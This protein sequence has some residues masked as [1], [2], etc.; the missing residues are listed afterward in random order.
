MF[1]I[2]ETRL[3]LLSEKLKD[4]SRQQVAFLPLNYFLPLKR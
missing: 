3:S 2:E 1:Q 4:K